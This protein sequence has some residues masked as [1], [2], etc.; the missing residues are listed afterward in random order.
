MPLTSPSV[1]LTDGVDV[2]TLRGCPLSRE[3]GMPALP[4][5]TLFVPLPPG[6]RVVDIAVLSAEKQTLAGTFSIAAARPPLPLSDRNE[7]NETTSSGAPE[8]AAVY[9]SPD[10]YPGAL[11]KYR[12]EGQLRGQNLA[13]IELFPLQYVPRDQRLVYLVCRT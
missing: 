7:T 9:Q 12:G 8:I 10:P 6:A 3:V 1:R 13:S 4:S 11:F 2:V 5:M